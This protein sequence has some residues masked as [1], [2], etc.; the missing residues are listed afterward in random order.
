MRLAV[1][2]TTRAKVKVEEKEGEAEEGGSATPRH[3]QRLQVCLALR[4]CYC[5]INLF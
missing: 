1:E 4:S 5:F 2:A 3:L